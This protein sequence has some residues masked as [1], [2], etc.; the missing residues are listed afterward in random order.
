MV[1]FHLSQPTRKTGINFHGKEDCPQTE[2]V[3]AID[4]S[5]ITDALTASIGPEQIIAVIAV[6]IGAGA[7]LVL[8]W[9]GARKISGGVMSA[10]KK[11]TLRF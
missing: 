2:V 7:G 3:N 11:G 1:R 6:V 5:A 4:Y 8:T 10:L 9:F